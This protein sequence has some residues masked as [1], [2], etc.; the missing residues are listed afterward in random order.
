MYRAIKQLLKRIIPARLL[1]IL[2]PV[3]RR[4]LYLFYSGHDFQCNVCGKGLRVFISLPDGG[5][6][7]PNCGSI[8][9]NRRLFDLLQAEYLTDG[10]RVLD[11]SPSRCLYRAMKKMP[12][13]LYTGTDYAGEFLSDKNYDITDLE[14]DNEAYDLVICYHVLEHVENDLQ[15][16]KELYRVLAKPGTCIIQ[17]PFKEGDTYE[18]PAVKTAEERLKHFGQND[19]VRIYSL[20]GLEERLSA[21]GFKVEIRNYAEH[22]NNVSGYKG[23]ETI[24]LCRK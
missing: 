19:H 22:E 20:K 9:R 23:R 7:C 15:A 18:N 10:L 2:E 17:T 21:C 6:L 12:D 8:S 14:V 4:I 13:I 11:F 24:L 3:F 1:Y 16:M 5:Q